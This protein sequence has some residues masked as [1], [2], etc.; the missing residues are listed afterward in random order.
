M[1]SL[2]FN[3]SREIAANAAVK[4]ITISLKLYVQEDLG[5]NLLPSPNRSSLPEVLLRKGVLKICKQI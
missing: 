2:V 4:D 5:R 3:V 1:F